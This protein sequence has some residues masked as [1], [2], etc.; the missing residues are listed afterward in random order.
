MLRWML[1]CA[2]SVLL[3]GCTPSFQQKL[4][5]EQADEHTYD[6]QSREQAAAQHC[7]DMVPGS[8]EH[9]NCMIAATRQKP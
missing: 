8:P 1:P 5:Q 3:C 6:A 4:K 2:L 7:S 9:M